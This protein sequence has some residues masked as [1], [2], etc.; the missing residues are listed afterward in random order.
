[1]KVT[2]RWGLNTMSDET[3]YETIEVDDDL[4]DEE[5]ERWCQ[6]DADDYVNN[7]ICAVVDSFERVTE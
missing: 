7:N 6:E 1:M 4:T 2:Y 3:H 5:I